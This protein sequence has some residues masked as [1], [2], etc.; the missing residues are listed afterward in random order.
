MIENGGGAR[1]AL[2][3]SKRSGSSG[4]GLGARWHRINGHSRA[5]QAP[6][7]AYRA[8]SNGALVDGG[9]LEGGWMS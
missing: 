5:H 1:N 6:P 8:I 3:L 7:R 4:Q 2:A 9:G